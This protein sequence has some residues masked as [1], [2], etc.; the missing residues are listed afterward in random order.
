MLEEHQELISGLGGALILL[1]LALTVST[2]VG[3]YNKVK[4]SRYIGQEIKAQ[5]TITVSGEG[6]VYADPDLAVVNFTVMSGKETVDQ[7]L[8]TNK[9]KMNAVISKLKEDVEEKDLKTT[10][11]NI[12]PRY[13]W[14]ERETFSKQGER[15]LVGYEVTQE[16]KV[17]LRDLDKTGE[18]IQKATDAGVN[19]VG[20]IRFTIDNR[21]QAKK[22]ARKKSY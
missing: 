6:E 15:V 17:K 19:R 16:V 2:A 4:E 1:L 12:Q 9:E 3:V 13:E 11:F 21:E 14:H 10:T 22:Q 7:A 20:N 18:I 5:N 8:Q